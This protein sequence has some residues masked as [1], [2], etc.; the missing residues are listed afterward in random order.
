MLL[1]LRKQ[2]VVP[3]IAYRLRLCKMNAS[4][5]TLFHFTKTSHRETDAKNYKG[6][7]FSTADSHSLYFFFN[8]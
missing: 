7:G 1:F 8:S 2:I 5:I 3:K 4:Y 6:T